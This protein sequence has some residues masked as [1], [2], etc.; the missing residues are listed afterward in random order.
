VLLNSQEV[1]EAVVVAEVVDLA[2][3][4]FE[5]V[6]VEEEEEEEAEVRYQSYYLIYVILKT[7]SDLLQKPFLLYRV[8]RACFT[9]RHMSL[10]MGAPE[11][12]STNL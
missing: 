5:V 6:D 8:T 1:L 11:T 2:E 7:F 12:F 4:D 3:E 9:V 10:S